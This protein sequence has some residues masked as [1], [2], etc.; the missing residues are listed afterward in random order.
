MK[1]MHPLLTKQCSFANLPSSKKGHFGEGVTA[2][3]MPKLHW[4][5]TRARCPMQFHGNYGLL[6]HATCLGLREDKEA[7]EVIREIDERQ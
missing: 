4:F 1:Q 2:E 3:D 5:K 6:R 7:R